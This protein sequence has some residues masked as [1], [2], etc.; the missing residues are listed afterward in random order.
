M[1]NLKNLFEEAIL[2]YTIPDFTKLRPI[3]HILWDIDGTITDPDGRPNQAV[4]AKIINSG[5]DGVSHSFATGRDANWIVDYLI[6]P[7]SKFHQFDRVRNSLTFFAE[8]G[9]V[10]MSFDPNGNIVQK[11]HPDVENHPLYK[12]ENDIRDILSNLVNNPNILPVA[13]GKKRLK[14]SEE[15]IY[16]ANEKGYVVDVNQQPIC[17]PYCW[18]TTKRAFATF[19]K[20]R[21]ENGAIKMFDQEPFNQIILRAIQQAGFENDIATEVIATAINIVPKVNGQKLGKSWA[22]GRAIENVYHRVKGHNQYTLQSVIDRTIAAGDGKAD[23]DFTTPIFPKNIARYI[24]RSE[25]PIIFVGSSSDLPPSDSPLLKNI[26]IQGTGHG[27]LS[28]IKS[29]MIEIQPT[30]GA[31]V[32]SEVL[33]F[34]KLWD[35]FRPF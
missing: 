8:V 10:E 2:M 11:V 29:N 26:I 27:R 30:K 32:I 7:L 14:A 20:N 35:Y 16:D 1:V 15:V 34:L 6:N 13:N 21:D 25:I 12:N 24:E 22:A 28:A 31:C 3:S 23:L 18:S 9:C 4:M 19:E 17:H 5:L 33:D